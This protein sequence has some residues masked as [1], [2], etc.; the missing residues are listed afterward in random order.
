MP[1][2]QTHRPT[3]GIVIRSFNEEQHIGRLLT[4]I[5]HQ[6]RPPE[7]IVLVDSGSTDATVE[8]ASRF[9][10]KVCQIAPE[11]FSFGRSLNLG[12][13]LIES[14]I[15]AIASAHVYPTHDTWL[16][17]LVAPFA[18]DQVA[19][20]YG[21]QIGDERTKFS[22]HQLL[23][24]W[25]PVQSLETQD[26]AFCNNANAAIRRTLWESLP[27]DE[28]L[29]GLEDLHWARRAIDKGYILSYV[30]EGMVVHVH[31]EDWSRLRNR[32]RREAIAHKRI[33]EE[34]RMGWVEAVRLGLTHTVSDYRAAAR[35]RVLLRNLIAIPSFHSAQFVGAY[36]GFAQEGD[37][38]SDLKRRF[39]YPRPDIVGEAADELIG[40]RIDYSTG[41]NHGD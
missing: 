12:C 41:E 37:A 27:Y 33:F 5:A 17:H 10:A 22:E 4:G 15:I 39:Y 3:V 11:D 38:S 26:H 14:E 1:S 35:E 2:R 36:Q 16:E 32:Y 8:I 29:T 7:E 24:R 31:E 30:A 21:R 9:G 20:S 13:S 18:N 6:T 34:H 25:F 23:L 28:N 40:R 19:L